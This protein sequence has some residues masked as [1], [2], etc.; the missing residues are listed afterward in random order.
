V[1]VNQGGLDILVN[2]AGVIAP[3]TPLAEFSEEQFDRIM[4]TNVKGVFLSMRYA[5]PH[6]ISAGR[7]VILNVSSVTSTKTLAGLGPYS[8][9]KRAVTSL[10]QAAALEAGPYGVRVNELLPGPTLTQ[11]VTGSASS[12]SG[13]EEGFAKQVPLGRLSEPSEQAEAALFLVSSRS[14]FV[15]GASLLVDGGFAWV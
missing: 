12:P 1:L 5:L 13:A 2:N 8:A 6:M 9:S 10:T 11:M 4:N 14:S 7:G 15:N 3:V